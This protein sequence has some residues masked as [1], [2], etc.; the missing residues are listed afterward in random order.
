MRRLPWVAAASQNWS[1]TEPT[2]IFA[3]HIE[4]MAAL[5]A[6]LPGAVVLS[7]ATKDRQPIIDRFQAGE[8]PWLICQMTIASTALTLTRTSNVVFA[9]SS[10]TPAD[11]MQ[12]AKRA[13]RIG[14]VSPVT[15]WVVSLAGSI[16]EAVDAVLVRKNATLSKIDL[17]HPT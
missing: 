4:N 3:L 9:E 11:M 14:K 1:F 6:G 7:G 16:D 5:A 10:W 13:H 17:A 15:A 12:A 2:V 8:I